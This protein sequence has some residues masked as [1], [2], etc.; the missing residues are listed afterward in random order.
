MRVTRYSLRY[1]TQNLDDNSMCIDV[2]FTFNVLK[3]FVGKHELILLKSI[4]R[5]ISKSNFQGTT[6][7]FVTL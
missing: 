6:L 2:M 7:C 4:S 1:C 3:Y 5:V